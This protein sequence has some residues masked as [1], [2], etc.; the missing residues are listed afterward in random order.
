M[1]YGLLA[2]LICVGLFKLAMDKLENNLLVAV[3]KEKRAAPNKIV[4]DA[5]YREILK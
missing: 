4:I 5:E 1:E 3:A 2:G